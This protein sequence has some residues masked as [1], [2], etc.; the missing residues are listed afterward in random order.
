MDIE[1]VKKTLV[2]PIDLNT[3]DMHEKAEILTLHFIGYLAKP[4]GICDKLYK[5]CLE[6]FNDN[7]GKTERESE[8]VLNVLKNGV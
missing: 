5:K 2:T 8:A 4:Y 6:A 1:D 3:K 7:R